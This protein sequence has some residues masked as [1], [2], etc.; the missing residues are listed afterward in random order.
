MTST[1]ESHPDAAELA[2]ALELGQRPGVDHVYV[3]GTPKDRVAGLSSGVPG[4]PGQL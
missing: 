4:C 2:G 1:S 3:I